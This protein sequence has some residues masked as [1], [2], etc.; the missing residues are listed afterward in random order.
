MGSPFFQSLPLSEFGLK[1]INPEILLAHPFDDGSSMVLKKDLEET[2][3]RMSYEE[4]RVYRKWM[5]PLLNSWDNIIGDVLAPFHFPSHPLEMVRFGWSA[6]ATVNRM[7]SRFPTERMK[8][9]WAGLGM[10]SQLPFDYLA[11]SAIGTLLLMAGHHCGWPVAEGGSASIA[12]ALRNYFVSLGGQIH[13]GREIKSLDELPRAKAILLDIGAHQLLEMAGKQLS[14]GYRRELKSF[15]QGMGVFKIDWALSG[16]TPF[17]SMD[18]RKALTLHLGG[19]FSEIAAGESAAW[20]EKR[21]AK[22]SVIFTQP[23]LLDPTR[24]PAGKHTAWLIV[25]CY[26]DRSGI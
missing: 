1:F 4:A 10:H 5:K 19:S 2:T 7:A 24:A 23:S 9:F 15:R 18:A 14:P 17:V 11:G 8:G 21:E 16:P 13:T 3:A 6:L 20:E 22:P 12:K 25:M 26:W